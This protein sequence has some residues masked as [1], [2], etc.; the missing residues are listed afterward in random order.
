MWEFGEASPASQRLGNVIERRGTEHAH[1][2]FRRIP[3]QSWRVVSGL[4]MTGRRRLVG[5]ILIGETL[6][7]EPV[8]LKPTG[9]FA[10]SAKAFG[11][12][13]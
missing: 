3:A 6:L 1:K 4:E 12:D 11:R 5:F 2:S 10:G 9:L 13:D 7:D 8:A